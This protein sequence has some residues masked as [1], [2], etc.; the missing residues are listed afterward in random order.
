M[1]RFLN[2][3]GVLFAIAN[4]IALAQTE[5]PDLPDSE[6]PADQPEASA[7]AAPGTDVTFARMS[8]EQ[9]A[10]QVRSWLQA[11]GAES[12][13]ATERWQQPSRLAEMSASELLDEVILT[14]AE[15]DPAVRR[16]VDQAQAAG[17]LDDVIFDGIRNTPFFQN[18]VSLFQ[19]RWLGQHR[20]YDESLALLESLKPDDVI[21]P[22]TLLFYRGV[23]QAELLQRKS[24]MDSLS[25]LLNNTV[26]VPERY[27]VVATALLEEL[28]QQEDEGLSQVA[29]LMKDV[30]RR[31]DL[32][33]A[34]DQTQDQEEAV[35]AALDKLMEELEQQQQQQ[36]QSGADGNG[37]QQ[38][39]SGS[40]GANRSQ[41]KGSSA[42]GIVDRKELNDK[43]KW[44]M[45]DDQQEAQTRELIRQKFPPNFLDQIG[46][47][48]KKLA[49]RDSN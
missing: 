45:L 3:L 18:Q 7:P 47:Y 11:A 10:E 30:G 19:G 31:L 20:F 15:V 43:G 49:E 37:S 12:S 22:A 8:S 21:D 5:S 6:G 41:I 1:I 24:A 29:R 25:L 23:C 38:N 13:A 36:Q 33:R 28:R 42:E 48:T 26:A 2:L 17:P 40:Q 27:Q 9:V 44:G 39:Q 35:I 14:F 4:S 46:R 34:G 16:L 32:G